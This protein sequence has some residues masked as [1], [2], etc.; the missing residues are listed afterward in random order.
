[1][2]KIQESSEMEQ[3][4]IEEPSVPVVNSYNTNMSGVDVSD[5]IWGYY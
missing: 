2:K 1:M 3:N 5:Q 4:N